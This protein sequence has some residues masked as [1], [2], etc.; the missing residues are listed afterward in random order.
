LR[1][2]ALRFNVGAALRL[3]KVVSRRAAR[4]LEEIE[5][6]RLLTAAEKK[7]R[8]RAIIEALYGTGAR[9]DYAVPHRPK[10]RR[11]LSMSAP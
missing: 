10:R 6:F 2:A 5:L 7:P 11:S 3:P 9:V 8:D 4:R 1:G